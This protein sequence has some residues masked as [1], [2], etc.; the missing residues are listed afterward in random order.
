[1]ELARTRISKLLGIE[2]TE[3]MTFEQGL[4]LISESWNKL[5]REQKHSICSDLLL[6]Q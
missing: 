1:M 4:N 5:E 3:D 6:K 2:I